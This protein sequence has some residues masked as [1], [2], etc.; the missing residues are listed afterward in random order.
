MIAIEHDV[1]A[2]VKPTDV[3]KPI[4]VKVYQKWTT[5]NV[6]N[7]IPTRLRCILLDEKVSQTNMFHKP[8]IVL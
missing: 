2:Q 1:V 3:N 4:E 5:R 8:I 6:R 7:R